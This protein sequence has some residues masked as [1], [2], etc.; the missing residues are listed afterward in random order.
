MVGVNSN[1]IRTMKVILSRPGMSIAKCSILVGGPDW[2]TSVL[3]GIMGLDLIPILIGTLPVSLLIFP[4]CLS[5]VFVYLSGEPHNY[6][7]ASTLST[8]CISATGMAQSGSM[9]VAAFYLEKAMA[10]EK[11]AIA[12]IPIDEEV[13]AADERQKA[14]DEKFNKATKWQVLPCWMRYWMITSTLLMTVSCYM[15][16]GFS[17][18]C[19]SP[20]AMS[21]TVDKALGGDPWSLVKGPGYVSIALF[22]I[23]SLM[24]YVFYKWAGNRAKHFV[25]DKDEG[26]V[27]F[28]NS[29]TAQDNT[30]L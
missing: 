16:M 21:D 20:F 29:N 19:F 12:A 7:W 1:M 10:E 14:L 9:V 24:Q 25:G 22:L 2:P 30:Q 27:S 18:I 26:D 15:V 5:G 8:V 17:S 28:S 23:S 6:E 13:A 4:T 3:C 11:D